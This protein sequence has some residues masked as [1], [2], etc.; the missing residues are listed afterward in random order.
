[1]FHAK[2][3]APRQMRR[4]I[5]DR[6]SDDEF[7][8]DVIVEIKDVYNDGANYQGLYFVFVRRVGT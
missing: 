7:G 8:G 5:S 1:M 3:H 6:F 2:T 4:I